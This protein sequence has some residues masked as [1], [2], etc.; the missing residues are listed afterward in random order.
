MIGPQGWSGAVFCG[1]LGVTDPACNEG[2]AAI[3][4]GPLTAGG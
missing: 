2:L 1:P 4:T 3:E